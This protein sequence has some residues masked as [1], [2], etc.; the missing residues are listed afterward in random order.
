MPHGL[1]SKIFAVRL[2]GKNEPVPKGSMLL[3]KSLKTRKN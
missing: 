2:K 3:E 1:Y